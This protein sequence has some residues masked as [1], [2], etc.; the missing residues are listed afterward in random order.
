MTT[1]EYKVTFKDGESL[2]CARSFFK[3]E[4]LDGIEFVGEVSDFNSLEHVCYRIGNCA[5]FITGGRIMTM[6]GN[7]EEEISR[8]VFLLD[9][10][11]VQLR[12]SRNNP[13]LNIKIEEIK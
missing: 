9:K 4:K 5:C 6:S 7:T 8:D 10:A 2:Y 12:K 11:V 1:R 3:N 13:N